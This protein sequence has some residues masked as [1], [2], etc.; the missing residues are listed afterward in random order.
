MGY[1]W[2]VTL[3]VEN[4]D[5]QLAEGPA[6]VRRAIADSVKK[7]LTLLKNPGQGRQMPEKGYINNIFLMT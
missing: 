6:Y 3:L 1:D 7:L 2:S 5:P 4:S